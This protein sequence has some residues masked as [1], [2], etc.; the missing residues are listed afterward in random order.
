VKVNRNST[1]TNVT[2]FPFGWVALETDPTNAIFLQGTNVVSL[3]RATNG[4]I[5]EEF[6]ITELAEFVVYQSG[7]KKTNVW[8]DGR[9]GQFKPQT[10][11]EWPRVTLLERPGPEIGKAWTNSLDMVFVPLNDHVWISIYECRIRDYVKCLDLME[12]SY[13][14]AEIIEDLSASGLPKEFW[15]FFPV[16]KRT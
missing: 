6:G 9:T 8:I 10:T 13:Y 2:V 1:Y 16:I 14:T 7:Y 5:F 12:A 3:P 15:E 4:W 11:N